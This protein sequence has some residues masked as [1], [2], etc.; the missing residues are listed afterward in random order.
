MIASGYKEHAN[1]VEGNADDPV[2]CG[3]VRKEGEERHEV[4]RDKEELINRTETSV[5]CCVHI[6]LNKG[7]FSL[8]FSAILLVL[9]GM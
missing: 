1:N 5:C 6:D 8:L 3:Y 9:Q 7:L 4:K 2:E